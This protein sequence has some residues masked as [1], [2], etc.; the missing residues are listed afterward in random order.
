MSDRTNWT[1]WL[2]EDLSLQILVLLERWFYCSKFGSDVEP[3]AWTL[4]LSSDQFLCSVFLKINNL[5]L[6]ESPD[7]PVTSL[8]CDIIMRSGCCF[9][10][11]LA[12]DWLLHAGVFV[13]ELQK[14][15]SLTRSEGKTD[16]LSLI[17]TILWF[18]CCGSVCSSCVLRSD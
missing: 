13:C 4:F 10:V 5:N 16:V 15:D 3:A 12:A 17:T 2:W 11:K 6:T 14:L 18:V 9:T 7:P 8:C 1:I